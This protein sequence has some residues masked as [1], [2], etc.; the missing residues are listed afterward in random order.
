MGVGVGV[1]TTRNFFIKS[2]IAS[3]M[4]TR[5]RSK[6]V[7]SDESS[8]QGSHSLSREIS[9]VSASSTFVDSQ[10]SAPLSITEDRTRKPSGTK[11][12]H[13]LSSSQW[14]VIFPRKILKI[15]IKGLDSLLQFV[16]TSYNFLPSLSI[17]EGAR[18]VQCHI[19]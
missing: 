8:S 4:L 16:V 18:H 12:A 2:I 1:V 3:K 5:S 9:N 13:H 11:H 6:S 15:I 17:E 19:Q 7:C 10:D 14:V